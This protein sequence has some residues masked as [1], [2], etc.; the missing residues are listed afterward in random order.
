MPLLEYRGMLTPDLRTTMAL[1]PLLLLL[2]QSYYHCCCCCCCCLLLDHNGIPARAHTDPL[3]WHI[4][5]VLNTLHIRLQIQTDTTDTVRAMSLVQFCAVCLGAEYSAQ[6]TRQ[7]PPQTPHTKNPPQ[8]I[9]SPPATPLPPP[10]THTHLH[11]HA[12]TLH[13]R[14]PRRRNTRHADVPG[15][16]GP[17]GVGPHALLALGGRAR[18]AHGGAVGQPAVVPRHQLHGVRLAA[19]AWRAAGQAVDWRAAAAGARRRVAAGACEGGCCGAVRGAHGWHSGVCVCVCVA[20]RYTRAA[21][22]ACAHALLLRSLPLLP[23]CVLPAYC[24][25]AVAVCAQA[26]PCACC[27]SAT[28]RR[29]RSTRQPTSG[30]RT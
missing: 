15:H 21:G 3:D 14:A 25:R 20:A 22:C 17:D 23:A 13:A 28:S 8:T 24:L 26:T 30:C 27:L 16:L 9:P 10:P 6:C 11:T 29:I 5:Q 1:L 19:R 12:R 2:L 7:G 4:Q 18:Q